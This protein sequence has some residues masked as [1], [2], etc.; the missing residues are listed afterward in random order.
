MYSQSS[1]PKE[2][3][4]RDGRPNQMETPFT[5]RAKQLKELYE[6]I[7]MRY[8]TRDERLDVLLSLKH[9]I[10]EHQCTL[11]REIAALADR[12]AD[13]LL[14]DFNPDK[15]E[16]ELQLDRLMTSAVWLLYG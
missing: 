4:G 13:L 6:C 9:T 12:E 5:L 10:G 1:A 11:T 15:L 3:V 7:N 2:W 14:R 16:G 8:V